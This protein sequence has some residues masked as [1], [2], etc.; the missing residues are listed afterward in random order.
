MMIHPF[1]P[2]E[3]KLGLRLNFFIFPHATFWVND[4]LQQPTS[5]LI[6]FRSVTPAKVTAPTDK[7]EVKLPRMVNYSNAIA[8]RLFIRRHSPMSHVPPLYM[9]SDKG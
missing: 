9:K 7:G 8:R 6:S 5:E 4:L 2:C 1:F 3:K